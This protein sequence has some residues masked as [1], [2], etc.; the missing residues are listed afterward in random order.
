MR[1]EYLKGK[2]LL[3]SFFFLFVEFFDPEHCYYL[4]CYYHFRN[5]A[6]NLLKTYAEHCP[7][8]SQAVRNLIQRLGLSQQ[9]R[10]DRPSN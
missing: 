3:N 8:A 6:P 10:T 1:L 7:I 5:Y 9:R 2:A 4:S